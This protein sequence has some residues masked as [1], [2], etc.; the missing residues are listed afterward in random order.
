MHYTA[1]IKQSHRL[2]RWH[3]VVLVGGLLCCLIAAAVVVLALPKASTTTTQVTAATEKHEGITSHIMFAGD[4]NWG[5]FTQRRAEASGKGYAYLMSGIQ[6]SERAAYD[7][8]IANF[9]CPVTSKDVPY[10]TQVA[11]LK[12]NC[13]PEYLSALA[14]YFTA[15]SLANNH[16]DNNGG[17]WGLQ[18]TRLNL[19]KSGIQYFG[20]YDMEQ[21][22]DICEVISV[23]AASGKKH[24]ELPLALCG[25]MYVVDARPTDAQLQVMRSYSKVMPVVAF[26]HMGIEYRN[27]AE[28]EKVSAY[29]RMIDNGADIVIGAHPHVIQNSENY[30]GRLIAYSVGNFL[31]DQQ[32]VSSET[33]RALTVG[34]KLSVPAGRAADAYMAAAGSCRAYK[35]TCLRALQ[36]SI[37]KRPTI[38]VAYDFGCYS[39]TSGVPVK[40]SAQECQLANRAATTDKLENLSKQW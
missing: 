5:R 8:W 26:P 12:F 19:E 28:S 1:P 17:Q 21:T 33:N 34:I 37:S 11:I 25:Y 40:G 20:T 14:K 22:G 38:R 10:A 23:P 18:Q 7:A 30:K 31:F 36:K 4:V 3:K 13:R 6:P 9:E 16:T 39:L 35:D 27:T 32:S 15:A 24:V 2:G 29:R